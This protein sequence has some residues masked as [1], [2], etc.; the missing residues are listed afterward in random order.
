MVEAFVCGIVHNTDLL[1]MMTSIFLL[2]NNSLI[3]TPALFRFVR[4]V[5]LR[6]FRESLNAACGVRKRSA[7]TELSC[8][9]QRRSKL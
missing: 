8:G 9:V 3:F 7:D 1:K 6:Y 5:R 2:V 4:F